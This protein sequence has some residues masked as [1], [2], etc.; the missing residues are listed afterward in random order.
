MYNITL[1]TL[2]RTSREWDKRTLN[3]LVHIG[4]A[5]NM[6]GGHG[7][8]VHITLHGE[9]S[10]HETGSITIN[11]IAKDGY[12]IARGANGDSTAQCDYFKGATSFDDLK[13]PTYSIGINGTCGGATEALTSILHATLDYWTLR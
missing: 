7:R 5:G 11:G 9:N 13:E 1:D 3:L 2:E 6:F 4:G 10:I 12:N 8:L